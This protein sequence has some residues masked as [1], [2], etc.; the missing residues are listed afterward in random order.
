M[1]PL[2]KERLLL[3]EEDQKPGKGTSLLEAHFKIKEF[4]F[5][6]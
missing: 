5:M 6:L 3:I 1:L 4:F 2:S